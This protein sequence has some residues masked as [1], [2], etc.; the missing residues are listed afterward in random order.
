MHSAPPPRWHARPSDV[1]STHYT[2]PSSVLFDPPPAPPYKGGEQQP[3]ATAEPFPQPMARGIVPTL[4]AQ[5]QTGRAASFDPVRPGGGV[6]SFAQGE[7]CSE[8]HAIRS[9][10][11]LPSLPF[12]LLPLDLRRYGFQL[13]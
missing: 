1:R 7:K 10:G 3:R 2:E 9:F 6:A 4:F 8:P 12:K 5:N 13:A 11:R